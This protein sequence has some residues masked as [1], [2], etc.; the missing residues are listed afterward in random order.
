MKGKNLAVLLVLMLLLGWLVASSI[1]SFQVDV[2][3]TNSTGSGSGSGGSGS[4]SSGQGGGTGTGQ[5]GGTGSG[6]GTGGFNFGFPTNLNFLGSFKLPNLNL[7]LPNFN[8][9][10]PHFNLTFPHLNLSGLKFGFFNTS[11]ISL[12]TTVG[13]G[14]SGGGSSGGGT[15]LHNPKNPTQV[16]LLHIN[17]TVLIALIVAVAALISI[18]AVRQIVTQKRDKN[19][20]SEEEVDLIE[21]SVVVEEQS[22]VE[23]MNRLQK[24]DAHERAVPFSGWDPGNGL[25]SFNID[26]KLPL[27]WEKSVPLDFRL[28]KGARLREPELPATN[29]GETLSYAPVSSCTLFNAKTLTLEDRFWVRA[30][31]YNDEIRRLFLLNF[32]DSIGN[33]KNMTSREIMRKMIEENTAIKDQKALE[34]VISMYERTF[35][36]KKDQGRSEF[37]NY[38]FS[39]YSALEDARIIVCTD[40]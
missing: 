34:S 4:G 28:A 26:L 20:Q 11:N 18:V 30:V 39:V 27:V 8:L 21:E 15:N 13:N 3:G 37:E 31:S 6:S 10:F 29:G 32:G 38:M 35:Y 24:M 12:G 9:K 33:F 2:S 7:S 40:D 14:T 19:T 36:G 17:T 16:N 25:I 22:E 1:S 5:T 23:K